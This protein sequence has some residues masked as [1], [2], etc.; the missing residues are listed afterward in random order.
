MK[1]CGLE[2]QVAWAFGLGL[3][4]LAMKL[5][6]IPD[7]RIL[8]SLDDKVM[9]QWST[10]AESGTF[11]FVNHCVLEPIVH[12]LSFWLP[13]PPEKEDDSSV[14][15]HNKEND[16]FD[17]VREVANDQVSDIECYDTFIH[18]KTGRMARGYR[19]KFLP[20]DEK[21]KNAAEFKELTVS[22]LIRIAKEANEKLGFVQK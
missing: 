19:L 22:Y 12:N 16:F 11:K 7:I 1:N 20:P 2:G 15:S 9:T 8:W 21:M 10:M 14:S 17:L 3:D 6:D 18:P 13:N 4:R 5:F